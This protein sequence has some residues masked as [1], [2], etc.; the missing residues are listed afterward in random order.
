M[1]RLGKLKPLVPTAEFRT[2]PPPTDIRT[3]R[4]IRQQDPFYGSTAWQDLRKAV[5][6]E[7]GR[8]CEDC[9]AQ[10]GRVYVDHV[11]ELK[12]GGA[13]LDRSNLRVLCPSCHTTKTGRVRGE[14][15]RS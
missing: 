14:R 11:V 9:G 12:D 10:P 13:P 1:A 5:V 15:L 2:C 4:A 3:G 7:R 8:Q 6:A